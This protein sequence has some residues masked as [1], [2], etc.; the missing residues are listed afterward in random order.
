[1]NTI[2][3]IEELDSK[4]APLVELFNQ[5]GIMTFESCDGG[6]EHT[7]PMPTI[8]FHGGVWEGFRAYALAIYHGFKVSDLRRYWTTCDGELTGPE[9]EITFVRNTLSPKKLK[10]TNKRKTNLNVL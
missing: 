4:I 2:P 3:D 6:T 5:N 7:F 9:W 1:M 10:H 8:R